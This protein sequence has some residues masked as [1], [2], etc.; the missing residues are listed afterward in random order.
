MQMALIVFYTIG[1]YNWGWYQVVL[2]NNIYFYIICI[3][4]MFY[5]LYY[6]AFLCIILLIY[7]FNKKKIMFDYIIIIFIYF[8]KTLINIFI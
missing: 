1:I 8:N 2:Y 3:Y 5:K 4:K 6:K 7:K